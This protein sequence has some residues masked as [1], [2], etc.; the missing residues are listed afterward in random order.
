[1]IATWE[2]ICDWDTLNCTGVTLDSIDEQ[3]QV[4]LQ[5]ITTT[6]LSTGQGK[7]LA[8][9]LAGRDSALE[10]LKAEIHSG[11][12]NLV[13]KS[14]HN[15]IGSL[16]M[17]LVKGLIG[18]SVNKEHVHERLEIERAGCSPILQ[19]ILPRFK[20]LVESIKR[21]KATRRR[22]DMLTKSREVVREFATILK[23]HGV[24]ANSATQGGSQP[25]ISEF[26]EIAMN[27]KREEKTGESRTFSGS[28]KQKFFYCAQGG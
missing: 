3:A 25:P 18:G 6:E 21:D 28:H 9:C 10:K 27:Q 15:A 5:F 4:T 12:A 26:S 20:R 7:L 16:V 17:N 2:L 14:L 23:F 19:H 11:A 13:V 24:G 22:F 1:M 8:D